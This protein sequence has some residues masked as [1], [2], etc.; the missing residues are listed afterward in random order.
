MLQ[1]Q[2]G[3]AC[4]ASKGT[5]QQGF[6]SGIPGFRVVFVK[7]AKKQKEGVGHTEYKLHRNLTA[8]LPGTVMFAPLLLFRETGAPFITCR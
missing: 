2:A 6:G 7:K 5:S 4:Q 1:G 3:S 8:A